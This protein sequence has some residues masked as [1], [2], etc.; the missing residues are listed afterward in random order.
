MGLLVPEA[1]SRLP[2]CLGS[3]PPWGFQERDQTLCPTPGT[4]YGQ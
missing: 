2:G 4:E 1:R 3:A